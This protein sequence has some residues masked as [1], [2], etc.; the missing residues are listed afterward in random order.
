MWRTLIAR[1]HPDSGGSHE[2][3][4]W[5]TATRDLVCG[6]EAEPEI[7]T[8]PP[9]T[10]DRVDFGAAYEKAGSFSELTRVAVAHAGE[11]GEPYARLL[12][13]LA[14]TLEAEDGPLRVQ[15]HQGATYRQLAAIAHR[16]GMSKAER[17]RWYR[18]CESIPLSQRHA[19]HILGKLQRAAA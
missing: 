6:G 19:G 17:V 2:L 3:F 18:V 10:A 7:E 14:D 5:A 8:P 15:Q 1:A 13:L 11:A 16:A 12:R 4:I 9:S